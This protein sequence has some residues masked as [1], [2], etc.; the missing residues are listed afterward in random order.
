MRSRTTT[1]PFSPTPVADASGG[2]RFARGQFRR[3]LL[4][5]LTWLPVDGALRLAWHVT[6][7]P[8]SES[9]LY[10]V[11]IDATTGEVLLRRN[12]VHFAEGSGRVMQSAAM[13]ALDPRRLASTLETAHLRITFMTPASYFT[14]EEMFII[15]VSNPRATRKTMPPINMIIAG[16]SSDVMA[17]IVAST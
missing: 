2:A 17:V 1:S 3:D 13:N 15:G 9:E 6:V 10:D 14:M 16:P 4:A 7:E 12:R 8:D 5:S 11:L